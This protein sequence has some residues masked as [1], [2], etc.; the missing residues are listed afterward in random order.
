VLSSSELNAGGCRATWSQPINIAASIASINYYASVAEEVGYRAC[1]Y[2]W[3]HPPKAVQGALKARELQVSMGWPVEVWDLAELSRRVPFID[4]HEGIGTV[5]FAPRDGL[6]NPNR[7]K[8]HY[9]EIARAS[10]VVFDDRIAVRA[11]EYGSGGSVTVTA[12][13]F[14][15]PLDLDAKGEVLSGGSVGSEV[16]T[17]TYRARR[18]INCAGA[19]APEIAKALGYACPSKPVRRQVC[20]FDCRDVDLTPYG[21]IVDPSGVYFH[22]EATNGLA[23]YANPDEPPGVSF[24]YDSDEFFMEKIWPALYERSTKFEALKHVTG[25][26]GLYEVSPDESAILGRVTSGDAG[27]HGAIFE[28]HSFSGHGAMHSYAAGLGLAELIAGGRYETVDFAPL[29][30]ERFAR[31]AEIRESLVI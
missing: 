23:G 22:P 21:M 9:R 8:N 13:R 24:R 26:A 2:L 16:D 27:R 17:V 20:I 4:K 29:S 11:A 6:V 12:Q 18:V 1:G 30:G 28:C 3:L 31:G 14:R 25:W 7:L 10:G 19:W 15:A 5:V